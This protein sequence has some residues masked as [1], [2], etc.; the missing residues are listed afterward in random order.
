M[1]IIKTYNLFNESL[2]DK[3]VGKS[4]D[5]LI[6]TLNWLDDSDKIR[7]IIKHKLSYD[8]LPVDLIVDGDLNCDNDLINL[9]DNLTVNGDLD[10]SYNQLTSL[11]NNLVVKCDLICR[12]NKL[13]SLPDDLVVKGSLYCYNNDLPKNIKKPIGVEGSLYK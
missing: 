2:K 10:C 9:P 3:I 1:K 12:N 11:P 5:E 8:L 7:E 4:K 6:K 13:T